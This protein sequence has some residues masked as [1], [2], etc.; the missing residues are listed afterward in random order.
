MRVTKSRPNQALQQTPAAQAD[1]EFTGP[2]AAG[3]AELGR[4]AAEGVAVGEPKT[5]VFPPVFGETEFR[6]AY[7]AYLRRHSAALAGEVRRLLDRTDVSPDVTDC[8]VQVFPDEYGDGHVSVYRYFNGRNRLVRKSDP[9]LYCGA[10]VRIADYAQ[11]L[12]LY[13]PSGYGFDTRDVTVRCVID[14]FAECWRAA[15]GEGYRFPVTIT[16]H[17]GFGTSDHL[18]LTRHAAPGT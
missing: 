16:G 10:V 3:A 12:P 6:E 15:G 11:D 2:S 4:S 14:W 17:D 5:K 18:P 1:C 9:S 13:D 8:E 7:L